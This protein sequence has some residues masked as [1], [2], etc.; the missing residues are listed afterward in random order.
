MLGADED[1]E[2]S[3]QGPYRLAHLFHEPFV[4]SGYLAASTTRL[5]IVTSVLVL[6]Q[7]Q[8][9][10]VAKQAAE[11]DVLS[12]GRLRLGV[13]I[14][15]NHVEYEAL[16]VAFRQRGPRLEEQVAVLRALW[17]QPR[18]DFKGRW[19][20]ISG[21]SLNP[22]PTQ[23]PIPIWFGGG[24]KATSIGGTGAPVEAVWERIGRLGDGWLPVGLG[25]HSDDLRWGLKRIRESA[26]K[27]ER[28]PATIG[29]EGNVQAHRGGPNEWASWAEQW[30]EQ[31]ATHLS[32]STGQAGFRSIDE[33][34]DAFRQFR[35]LV[36]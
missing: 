2:E 21:A 18:V 27:A 22:L 32:F 15:W 8:T 30:Q 29:L 13:G 23:R 35:D 34:L 9:I 3:L 33:H 19:H 7:R 36:A 20:T 25:P 5:G 26:E 4:L 28:D 17:S 16:G 6:P 1:R 24:S 12:G 11:V 10:L 31:G 14:G